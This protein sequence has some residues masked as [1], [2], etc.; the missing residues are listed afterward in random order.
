LTTNFYP[1]GRYL[2]LAAK[3]WDHFGT[4]AV[5]AYKIGHG[6]AI[7]QAMTARSFTDPSN[8]LTQL[9]QAYAMNA[10]ADHF[11]SDLFSSGHVRTPRKELYETV[12]PSAAGSYASRFMHDEDSC[13]GL[14]VTNAAGQSWT[15][16]GDKRFFDSV[17]ADNASMVEQAVQVSA[18]EVWNAFVSGNPP[19]LMGALSLIPNLSLV[20][21]WKQRTNF[22][23]LFISN[24]NTTERR[25][26]ISNKQDYS[27]TDDWWGWSTVGMLKSS[28]EFASCGNKE[29]PFV[30]ASGILQV[31]GSS[32]LGPLTL[33]VYSATR[34]DAGFAVTWA[35]SPPNNG[36]GAVAWLAGDAN[37]DGKTDV[38]QL[39]DNAGTLALTV[40]SPD[41]QGGYAQAWKGSFPG[42]GS[43]AVAW[44]TGDANGD[45][46]TDVFQLWGSGDTLALTVFSPNFQGVYAQAWKGTFS[47]NGWAAVAWLAGDANG[48]GKTDVLQL[49]DNA[50]TLALTVFSP[51]GQGGYAQAWKGSF[52][53]NGSGAVAWLA[54]PEGDEGQTYFVQLWDN[55]GQLGM[56][57]YGPQSS[58]PGYRVVGKSASMGETSSAL[59]WLPLDIE[60]S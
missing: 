24:K 15:A 41:G 21:D 47:N 3:N 46:K 58:G 30:L 27:W 52:P 33:I 51:D 32:N 34:T 13:W 5:T 35:G 14:K 50:G 8:K 19:A 6:A 9:M 7:Q 57:V 23:P 39:W 60:L 53:G 26:D 59:A 20:S 22:S 44:L 38:L 43:G 56:T 48:D 29:I 49:W 16:Y 37:G 28:P 42:N 55:Q 12:T 4:H 25:T 10:F 17:N 2:K 1:F 31:T 11:L 54:I 40:F 36:P 18:N 45:G